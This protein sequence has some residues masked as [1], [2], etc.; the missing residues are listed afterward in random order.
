[1]EKLF[2]ATLGVAH[3]P[4]FEGRH[5]RAIHGAFVFR[6]L[7]R[8]GDSIQARAASTPEREQTENNR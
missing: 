8:R 6:C 5:A 7:N 4:G 1:M 3:P 2:E